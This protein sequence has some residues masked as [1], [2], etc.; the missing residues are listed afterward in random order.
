MTLLLMSARRAGEGE[1]EL[2]SGAWRGWRPTHLMGARVAGKVLGIVGMGRIGIAMA[3]RARHGFGMRILCF[4]RSPVPGS[5]LQELGAAQVDDLDALLA[6]VDFLSLH[7]PATPQTHHLIDAPRLARMRPAAHLINSARGAVVDER[8]LA[9][10]LRSGRL[11][12]AGLD[13]YEQEPAVLPALLKLEN[14]VLLPHLGSATA[15]TRAAMGMRVARN[16]ERFFA[17]QPPPDRCI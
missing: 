12:G 17:G 9:E 1:R 10:A 5:V 7:C 11:A 15:E 14:A 2:R 3:R 8:A 13:V 16:L 6:K 4:S